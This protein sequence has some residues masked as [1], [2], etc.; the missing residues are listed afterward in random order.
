MSGWPLQ[1]AAACASGCAALTQAV[2]ATLGGSLFSKDTFLI[3]YL[4]VFSMWHVAIAFAQ[5]M[6]QRRP[7]EKDAYKAAAASCAL[8]KE[9]EKIVTSKVQRGSSPDLIAGKPA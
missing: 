6:H 7:D 3:C 5:G 1:V 2:M 9:K 8:Q 4:Y